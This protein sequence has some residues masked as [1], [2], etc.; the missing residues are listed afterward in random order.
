MK[1]LIRS[2][3]FILTPVLAGLALGSL[4]FNNNDLWKWALPLAVFFA[5]LKSDFK[6]DI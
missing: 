5:G 2:L 6:K 1:E 4:M 3:C